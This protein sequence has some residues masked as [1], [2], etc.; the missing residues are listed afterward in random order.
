MIDR[1]IT[2]SG[3]TERSIRSG[4]SPRDWLGKQQGSDGATPFWWP[5][6]AHGLRGWMGYSRRLHR[7]VAGL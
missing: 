6:E 1:A 2:K 3:A 7:V 5:R 4:Q